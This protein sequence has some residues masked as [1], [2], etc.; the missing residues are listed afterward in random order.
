MA[1]WDTWPPTVCIDGTKNTVL[2]VHL[3]MFNNNNMTHLEHISHIYNFLKI[4]VLRGASS[5]SLLFR[6]I[7]NSFFVCFLLALDL[8]ETMFHSTMG[9]FMCSSDKW[10]FN[11]QDL[12]DQ[13]I[14]KTLKFLKQAFM[15]THGKKTSWTS[16]S[17]N[18]QPQRE[19]SNPQDSD[20]H[21]KGWVSGW[22]MAAFPNNVQWLQP[23][24]DRAHCYSFTQ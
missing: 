23:R 14:T 12:V 2:N 1:Q 22:P 11:F 17:V 8:V 21:K 3:K 6:D 5:P 16:A 9:E 19:G 13:F 20:L 18:G 24:L 10:T 4:L 7:F 15:F